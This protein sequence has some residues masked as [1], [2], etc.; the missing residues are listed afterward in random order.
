MS[1]FTDG[2]RIAKAKKRKNNKDIA[3]FTG[4]SNATISKI[5]SGAQNTSFENIEKI[6]EALE[7]KPSEIYALGEIE[8]EERKKQ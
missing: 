2:V 3:D 7:M 4:I 8:F 5:L 1:L 6:C